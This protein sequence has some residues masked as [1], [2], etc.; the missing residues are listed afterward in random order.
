MKSLLKP[1][2]LA[3]VVALAVPVAAHAATALN[4]TSS[5]EVLQKVEYRATGLKPEGRYSLRIRST[6]EHDGRAYRCAAYLSGPRRASGSERFYGSLPDGLQCQPTSGEGPLWQPRT[7]KGTYQAVV[8][9]AAARNL[10][11]PH[12]SVAG[13]TVRVR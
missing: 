7:S 4:G 3:T 5:L 11:D 6:V 2:A 8:C 13:K 10:C 1:A 9:V 12:Y